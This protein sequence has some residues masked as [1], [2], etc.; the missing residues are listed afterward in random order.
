MRTCKSVKKLKIGCPFVDR[1]QKA[2]VMQPRQLARVRPRG[3]I[4]SVANLIVG[5]TVPVIDC[6][7]VT[8]F[9]GAP[10]SKYGDAGIAQNFLAND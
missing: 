3:K 7:M 9:P 6:R 5:P 4:S 10:A 1:S 2:L 8:Y